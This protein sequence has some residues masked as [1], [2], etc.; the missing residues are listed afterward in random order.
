MQVKKQPKVYDVVVIGSGA[1]GGMAAWNLTRQG[2]NVLLLDA[3]G[4]FDRSTFWTH[5]L[6]YEARERH[7]RGE[8]PPQFY[9][10]EKEQPVITPPDS[11]SRAGFPA[12]ALRTGDDQR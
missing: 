1:S 4:R 2:V 7:A 11:I 6:P 12:A 9:L 8:R 5:V 3:G 10:S